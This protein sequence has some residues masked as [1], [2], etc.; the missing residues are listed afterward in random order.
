MGKQ[1]SGQVASNVG[2]MYYLWDRDEKPIP[3]YL[4]QDFNL[5]SSIS[6]LLIWQHWHHGL[7]LSGNRK[8]RPMKEIETLDYP[9]SPFEHINE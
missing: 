1:H 9:Q 2:E 8:V 4:P 6:P 5:D 7:T 3:R